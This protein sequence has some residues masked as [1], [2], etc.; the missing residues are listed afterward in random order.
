VTYTRRQLGG[1]PRILVVGF[2]DTAIPERL[3]AELDEFVIDRVDERAWDNDVPAGSVVCVL[4]RSSSTG[5]TDPE[6]ASTGP[7]ED[8]VPR[9]VLP[10]SHDDALAAETVAT[11]G[12]YLP[13]SDTSL[14]TV[15]DVVRDAAQ[16]GERNVNRRL[17]T[18]AFEELLD[19]YDEMMYVKNREGRY[20]AA[21]SY[22]HRPDPSVM[23]GR[24]A[25]ELAREQDNEWNVLEKE[26]EDALRVV[27]TGDPILGE[28]EQYGSGE[29]AFW[30][31]RTAYPWTGEDGEPRGTIS[32][33]REVSEWE[34]EKRSMRHRIE[35]L[36]RFTS[37][38]SHDLR[39]PLQIAD[40]YLE[41]ART[42]DE[43]ALE[44]VEEANDRMREL[45]GDLEALV[46]T[47][48][49][50]DT[51]TRTTRLAEL[52][53]DVW[54]VVDRASATLH[55]EIPDE[56]VVT[57]AE[58]EVRPI[59]ENL[60]KNAIDHAGPE[61]TVWIGALDHG[62]YVEDDGPGVSAGEREQ[63]F[64]EGYTTADEGT[65]TGL[66]IV[67]DAVERLKWEIDIRSGRQGGAKVAVANVPMATDPALGA[68][69]TVT[70]DLD[71][72][73]DVGNVNADGSATYEA[74]T[75]EWVVT[76][77]GDD[78]YAENNDFHFA[79]TEVDGPASVQARL[80]DLEEINHYSKGGVIV[81]DSVEDEATHGYV[82]LTPG[83][84]IETTWR[85]T[86]GSETVSQQLESSPEDVNWLRLD[87]VGER[88]TCY[89]SR[90]GE[91]WRAID[92]RTV[93]LTD[94]IAVGLAVCSVVPRALCTARFDNVSVR[95]LAPEG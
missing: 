2:Q 44:R 5:S 81:R 38:V 50:G 53:R 6:P 74:A 63:V 12:T 73:R 28:V 76:G 18:A 88:V 80:V 72:S 42:G 57:A 9:I 4:T 33:T 94:P 34:R 66:A 24:T 86:P 46:S 8:A 77:A 51:E 54:T 45:I 29:A 91:E 70:H 69:T 15:V 87:R 93:P 35:Q 39:S 90:R 19:S 10:D 47:D 58:S 84:G 52:A 89:V 23:L 25:A 41:L 64:E 83:H 95:E 43:A 32:V 11:G 26:H 71:D 60:F 22:S 56:T 16:R 85:Q 13:L 49:V 59:L 30:Y 27:E 17:R 55:V 21:S 82:G 75:D 78:I 62:F 3:D 68:A 14:E 7:W 36:E 65:G 20:V 92:Q 67:S 37:F 61:V 40:G 1:R 31:E 48:R 79:F